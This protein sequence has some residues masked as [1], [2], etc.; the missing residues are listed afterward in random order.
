MGRGQGGGGEKGEKNG[1]TVIAYSLKYTKK[2]KIKC[3]CTINNKAKKTKRRKQYV[4]YVLI[5]SRLQSFY[6][7]N[8]NKRNNKSLLKIKM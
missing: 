7:R 2:R 1:T 6:E 5:V 4:A 8:R 3:F